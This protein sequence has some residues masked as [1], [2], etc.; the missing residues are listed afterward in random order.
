MKALVLSGGS[1]TRLRP[2]SYSMPK[3]LIPIANKPVLQHVLENIRDLGVT[4]IGIIV[5]ERLPQISAVLG[6]GAELGVKITY[7]PQDRPLGLAHC[8][9]LARPFLGN[10]DFVMYLG[11]N[12]LTGGVR[13]IAEEFAENR[14]AAQLVVQ[15]VA[16]PR[17]FGVAELGPDGRVE[18]LVEKPEEPRSD[19]ALIGVYFFTPAIHAA[20]DAIEPSPRGELEITDAIQWL[21]SA[22]ADVRASEYEGY[23]KDTGRVEDV[24]DCNRTL[25]DDLKP[26]TAGEV[27]DASTLVGPVV[28]EQGA[29]VVRSRLVGPAVIASGTVVTDSYIGPYTSIGKD[30]VL[31]DTHIEQSIVLDGATVSEVRG[32][33]S[34]LIGRSAAVVPAEH[35]TAH[36]R[37]VVGDHTRVEVA[38]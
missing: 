24:L 23:W 26:Y 3:Q 30:C 11:D 13:R 32:L 8:V 28:V 31:S 17:A 19:L 22:G 5:G 18:R 9:S 16:D 33:H 27:D 4:E 37:L 14:P 7:I 38:A 6:D 29:K 35:D 2:F 21:V 20:V 1:G 25:L 34:S 36:H 15:K 12:M 10:D